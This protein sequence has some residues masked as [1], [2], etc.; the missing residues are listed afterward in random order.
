[1]HKNGG[2]GV[3]GGM[4]RDTVNLSPLPKIKQWMTERSTK[5]TTNSHQDKLQY[6]D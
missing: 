3:G 4:K 5:K 1:M 2:L 6:L